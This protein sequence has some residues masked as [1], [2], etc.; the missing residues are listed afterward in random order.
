[1][2]QGDRKGEE[3]VKLFKGCKNEEN[4]ETRKVTGKG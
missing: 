2:E 4:N 1:M 3:R